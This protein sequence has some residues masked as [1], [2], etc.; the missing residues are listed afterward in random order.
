MGILRELLKEE[1][2]FGTAQGGNDLFQSFK[3]IKESLCSSEL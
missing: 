1:E 2:I 3:H